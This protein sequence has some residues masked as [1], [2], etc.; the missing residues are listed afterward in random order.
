[1]RNKVHYPKGSVHN[2]NVGIIAYAHNGIGTATGKGRG[3]GVKWG[4]SMI[5]GMSLYGF[6]NSNRWPLEAQDDYGC[7]FGAGS[8]TGRGCG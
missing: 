6:L 3:Y 5:S 2:G 4:R 8:S 1:M 7:S